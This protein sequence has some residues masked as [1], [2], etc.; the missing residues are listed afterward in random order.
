MFSPISGVPER[1]RLSSSDFSYSDQKSI[2]TNRDKEKA[3]QDKLKS[4]KLKGKL[5]N[6]RKR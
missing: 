5:K 4:D 3:Y 6:K 2:Q 1:D